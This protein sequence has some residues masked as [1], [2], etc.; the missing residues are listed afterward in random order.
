MI[1][2]EAKKYIERWPGLRIENETITGTVEFIGS[3]NKQNNLFQV[4]DDLNYSEENTPLYCSFDI[5]IDVPTG[6]YSKLPS[7]LIHETG[8][9]IE[10]HINTTDGKACLCSPLAENEFLVPEFSF[11]KYFE[12]LVLPFLYSQVYF[13]AFGIWPWFDYSHGHNGILESYGRITDPNTEECVSMLKKY[14]KGWEMMRPYLLQKDYI[15]GHTPCFCGK[16]NHM[17]RC[18]PFIL[19]GIQRLKEDIKRKSISL[20][21][22]EMPT[23][24]ELEKKTD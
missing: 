1:T 10:R 13:S 18:H 5:T 23:Q 12:E 7:L 20:E 4:T 9:G 8:Y 19:K 16:H 6:D 15:K 2:T 17:R 11:E 14:K 22:P 24:N 21:D 3:Y